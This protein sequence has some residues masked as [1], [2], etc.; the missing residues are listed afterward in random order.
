MPYQPSSFQLPGGAR[1]ARMELSGVI[2]AEEAAGMLA[3][4]DPGGRFHGLSLLVLAEKVERMTSEARSVFGGRRNPPEQ[5]WMAIVLTNPIM[6]VTS[7]FIL[8][9][10]G[11]VKRRLFPTEAEAVRWLD[12]K[13]MNRGG[14]R[15]SGE[16]ARPGPR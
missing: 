9:M 14:S 10:N 4:L 16:K 8:R 2:T 5:E 13:V 6:R 11:N 15:R 12:D 1:C 7:N 3:H